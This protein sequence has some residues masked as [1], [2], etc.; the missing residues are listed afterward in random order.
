MFSGILKPSRRWCVNI[1]G[2]KLLK[3]FIGGILCDDF[4]TDVEGLECFMFFP[5]SP[6]ATRAWGGVFLAA[7][8]T[9]SHIILFKGIFV[10]VPNSFCIILQVVHCACTNV[11]KPGRLL[12]D[13]ISV[14]LFQGVTRCQT[15]WLPFPAYSLHEKEQH[16]GELV[17]DCWVLKFA[18]SER[19]DTLLG[20]WRRL[21]NSQK[22][23]R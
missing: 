17:M 16:K 12:G 11:R 6:M 19:E 7:H 1:V 10:P 5:L 18:K 22:A 14:W 23:A 4:S 15:S 20:F 3:R 21:Q 8:S 2:K 13:H 9:Q